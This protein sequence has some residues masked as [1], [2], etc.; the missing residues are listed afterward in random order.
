[1]NS[2]R[3]ALA[4]LILVL[5]AAAVLPGAGPA[6]ADVGPP[7]DV[8][9][10][11]GSRMATPG[12][13]FDGEIEIT[14]A[15]PGFL[16]DFRLEGAGWR[17][18]SLEAP[19]AL[20][21]E[22]SG[23]FTLRFTAEPKDPDQKLV[24]VFLWDD[25][26]IRRSFD[27]SESH[28]RLM[29]E[30]GGVRPVAGEPLGGLRSP[31]AGDPPGRSADW[32]RPADKDAPAY[33]ITVTGG[34]YY[35]LP[36]T[37]VRGPIGTDEMRVDVFADGMLVAT[38]YTN[39][40]G[41][42]SAT[43][44][45]GS[46]LRPDIRVRFTAQNSHVTVKDFTTG[47]AYHW[48]TGTWYDFPGTLLDVGSLTSANEF[49]MPVMHQLQTLTRVWRWFDAFGYGPGP[50]D[51]RFPADGQ[52]FGA[53]GIHIASQPDSAW[54]DP[55]WNE[56]GYAHEYTHYWQ[57]VFAVQQPHDYCNGIC[58]GT[59]PDPCG[60]CYW[61][62][63]NGAVVVLEGFPGFT[64]DIIPKELEVQYGVPLVESG[65]SED[66]ISCGGAWP[67]PDHTEGLYGALLRDIHDDTQDQHQAFAP[68]RDRMFDGAARLVAITHLD[69]PH[70]PVAFLNAYRTR[71]PTVNVENLWETAMNCGI[72]MD[73][74]PPGAVT[75]LR[76]TS[77]TVAV[78]S[79]DQTIDLAWTVA[80]DDASGVQGYSVLVGSSLA[81]PDMIQDIGDVT[82]HHTA[83]LAAG[84]YYISIRAVDRAGRWSASFA[85]S[86]PYVIRSPQ[87]S[88]LQTHLSLGWTR[89]LVPRENNA[90]TGTN[91]PEPVTLVG[92]AASTYWNLN[93]LNGGEAATGAFS[94]HVYLDG[95]QA[96]SRSWASISGGGNYM[97]TNAGPLTVRGGRHTFEVF[98]DALEQVAETDETDNRWAHQW[99]WT[100]YL[101]PLASLVTR[102]TPPEAAA[103]WGS[104]SDG[105]S[106]YYNC[107]GLSFAT[108]NYLGSFY[109]WDAVYIYAADNAKDFDC[110]L[111]THTTGAGNGFTSSGVLGYST[112]PAGYLD[113]V[114]VNGNTQ[115]TVTR[116]VGVLNRYQTPAGTDYKA[117]RLRASEIVLGNTRATSL[118]QGAMMA[119]SRFNVDVAD[120]G[121]FTFTVAVDPPTQ[122]MTLNL[123][124]PTFT[125]GALS[126]YN[127]QV[128]VVDGLVKLDRYLAL[129]GRHALIVYRDPKDGSAACTVTVTIEPAQPDFLAFA[130]TGWHSPVVPRP[131]YD[132]TN[133][134]AALPDTLHGNQP[135][136]YFNFAW[137]NR[138]LGGWTGDGV[139]SVAAEVILDGSDAMATRTVTSALPGQTRLTNDGSGRTVSGGRHTA[140]LAIDRL[141]VVPEFD[142]TNNVWGEQYCWSPLILE[143]GVP[144]SRPSPPARTGGWADVRSGEPLYYNCDGLRMPGV[145]QDIWRCVGVMP[146][147]GGDVDLRLH[148]ALHG[149]KG[150]FAAPSGGSYWGQGEID[151]VLVNGRGLPPVA[152]PYPYAVD[153]GVIL[154]GSPVGYLAEAVGATALA[155]A[156]SRIYG[157][158]TLGSEHLLQLYELYLSPG[159]WHIDL[160]NLSGVVDWGLSLYAPTTYFPA[161][162]A[163]ME[164]GISWQNG[165]GQGEILEVTVPHEGWYALVVWKTDATARA[166]AGTYRLRVFAGASGVPGQTAV[167]ARTVL[168]SVLPNPFNP[169]TEV[170]FDLAGTEAVELAVY[171]LRG[172]RLRTL[173]AGEQP[174]G[175]HRVGW[176]GRDDRGGEVASGVYIL[177][178]T[179]GQ[180]RQ[181][182]KLSLLK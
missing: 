181:T 75:N 42:F 33:D 86:G 4:G 74:T 175:R 116:D 111:H 178:L 61:C 41:R 24:L 7:V 108:Q 106:T 1:M 160:Q 121:W 154:A 54:T 141:G 17:V 36:D 29:T 118:G 148:H 157:P 146:E 119:F 168:V 93:G 97:V 52:F 176:N 120:T 18:T 172:V 14:A 145:A 72:D 90:A 64:G 100:P 115:G 110:R 133:A 55:A 70:S 62:P 20:R 147:S 117:M 170:V 9:L 34:W 15:E 66:I 84:S 85:W 30:G 158:Y 11:G 126:Q 124:L 59:P 65:N 153:A 69:N 123:Y 3:R 78:A 6:V 71:Y 101:L 132:P 156:K 16:S 163:A 138:N 10:L 143:F 171:D 79:P 27:L 109:S 47:N 25:T 2:N 22:K 40:L 81:L 57:S 180:Y 12:E 151:F 49:V 80:T 150:G 94:A 104:V 177:R 39:I 28:H 166:Q 44:S 161:K 107:D 48:W 35:S 131:G 92:N 113:A 130:P 149:A 98:H 136:S 155:P 68:W 152:G 179:A 96:D 105:S 58:D 142:E 43:F 174:A 112:R 159:P 95:I 122:P 125:N 82:V 169:Q 167:P 99:V 21:L 164:G 83:P 26:P 53:G 51:V 182:A 87:P 23:R 89:P 102:S 103:G 38:T 140:A 77:H 73:V 5:T 128:P 19:P 46:F 76:S 173:V 56:G 63:E 127:A 37:F 67:D 135:L 88:D 32:V 165:G 134:N 144:A 60:H 8:G 91:V 13:A 31:Y 139:T 162:S 129:T 137:R 114:L 45:S 50:V